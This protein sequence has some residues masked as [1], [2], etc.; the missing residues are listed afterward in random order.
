MIV[1]TSKALTAA[2]C[3]IVGGQKVD[4]KRGTHRMPCSLHSCSC[5]CTLFS[6]FFLHTSEWLPVFFF[7]ERLFT[8]E[9]K[10]SNCKQLWNQVKRP[11]HQEAAQRRF[12]C[13]RNF[14]HSANSSILWH[15]LSRVKH[16]RPWW[17]M[18][19]H[20]SKCFYESY[21][22]SILSFFYCEAVCIQKQEVKQKQAQSSPPSLPPVVS[23]AGSVN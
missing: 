16:K 5:G 20:N 22:N 17:F 10:Q 18:V 21:L 19:Q 7:P 12:L 9:G 2:L 23:I 15:M 13:I 14:L 8:E 4:E 11:W 1:S 6:L 3:L